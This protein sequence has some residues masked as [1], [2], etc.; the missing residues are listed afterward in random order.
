MHPEQPGPSPGQE[1]AEDDEAEEREVEDHRGV[2][3]EEVGHAPNLGR[4]GAAH[5]GTRTHPL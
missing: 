1:P 3:E 2:A 5:I 4:G